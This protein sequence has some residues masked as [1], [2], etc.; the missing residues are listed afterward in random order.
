MDKGGT[1]FIK[2]LLNW[3]QIEELEQLEEYFSY[4]L[5]I[6]SSYNQELVTCKITPDVPKGRLDPHPTGPN[7]LNRAAAC[8]QF[9]RASHRYRLYRF[10]EGLKSIN[11]RLNLVP[12]NSGRWSLRPA[13]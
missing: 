13:Y 6:L 8:P 7:D 10:R 5:I 11:I 3:L 1:N 12:C 2:L 9:V 4:N